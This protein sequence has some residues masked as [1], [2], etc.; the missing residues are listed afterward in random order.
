[1]SDSLDDSLSR[2]LSS[3]ESDL[4][5]VSLPGPAAARR[6]AAQRTRNQVTGGVL[7]GVAAVA[8]GVFAVSPPDFVAS[9]DP[10]GTPTDSST[11]TTTPTTPSP[12]PTTPPPTTPPTS[13]PTS[14]E[15]PGGDGEDGGGSG[16]L[17][18]PPGALIG[19][20]FLLDPNP[21]DL[22]WAEVPADGT[23][24]PCV[25]DFAD[26]AAAVSYETSVQSR[27]D[28]RVEPAGT[29]AEA[30][31]QQL[32][33]EITACAQS[34]D[35]YFLSDVWRLTGV[36]D[37]G[38]LMVWHGPPRT[39]ES[40]TYVSASV[41]R[42]GGFISAAFRGWDGQEYIGPPGAEDAIEAVSVL[43]A[44]SD[45]DCPGTPERERLYPEPVGDVDGWL[46]IDDLAEAGLTALTDGSEVMDS[47]DAGGSTDYGFVGLPRDPFAD[48][49]ATLEQRT[50]GDPLD[51]G[52][53]LANQLRATFPDA[54]AARAH[55][56]ALAAAAEQPTQPGDVVE[57]TGTVSGDGYD[58]TS[59][60]LT[61]TEYGTSWLYGA[62]VSGNVVTAVY[63]GLIDDELTP[64]QMRQLID[65][66]AQRIGG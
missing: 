35:D 31:L 34:G 37:E 26:T 46:T 14:D 51:V 12:E 3:L 4:G 9:P 49:A 48:G 55:Y 42:A 22:D 44:V 15:S 18:V 25:P 11:P 47:G 32:R 63:Y 36:G 53:Q 8:L 17:V 13:D 2:R 29:G 50:Y 27:F 19:I 59:W 52:G 1:M 16:S 40:A 66:A 33:D 41:V 5:G 39:E 57:N 61:N 30:R 21:A 6:R 54:A 64:D 20:D 56:D 23:W 28:H 45:V 58:G 24:L 60:Q 43:C 7:A 65:L 62:A 10:A 38:Y